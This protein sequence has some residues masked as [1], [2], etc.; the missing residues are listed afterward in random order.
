M[1]KNVEIPD[2]FE[3]KPRILIFACEND[4]MPVFDMI[5]MNRIPY[6][7][8]VRVIPLRCLGGTNLVW[9]SDALSVGF[10]GVMFMGCKLGDDYQCHF[11]KG[12]EIA[13]TRLSKVQETIG[14]LSLEPERVQQFEVS[15]NDYKE[16]PKMIEEFV[17][18]IERFGPNP[19]KGM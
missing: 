6:S 11:I 1:I 18:M 12:S 5:A 14:R 7:S 10:D 17:E 3:E 19:F 4:A 9:V 16:V 13:N 15:M 2:E 8:Y